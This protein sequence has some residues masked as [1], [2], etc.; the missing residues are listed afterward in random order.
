[1]AITMMQGDSYPV[2]IE[3]KQGETKLD[4]SMV[5]DV[6]I[7][8]AEQLRK[9]YSEG[10]VWYDSETEKW[11]I[12]P[13]QKETLEMH[14]GAH[15]VIARVKYRNQPQADVKGINVGKVKIIGTFSEEVL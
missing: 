2:F 8:I 5:D 4:P 10:G 3:L 9:V 11:Y 7:C 1:M 15:E 6:E 14:E 12:R 13:S